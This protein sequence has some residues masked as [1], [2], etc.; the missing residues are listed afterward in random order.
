MDANNKC[1]ETPPVPATKKKPY[2]KPSFRCE[3]VFGTTALSCGKT[4]NSSFQYNIDP[5]ASDR[6]DR[7]RLRAPEFAHRV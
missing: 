6:W 7:A 2:A 4:P 3:K 1:S 5:K